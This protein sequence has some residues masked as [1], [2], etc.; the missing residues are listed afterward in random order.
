MRRFFLA[1]AAALVLTLAGG[2]VAAP[3][4]TVSAPQV[5]KRFKT[6]TTYLLRTNPQ[7]SYENVKAIGYGLNTPMTLQ[8]KYGRFV[9]YVL[10]GPDVEGAVNE[11]LVDLHTGEVGAPDA[12]GIYW[13]QDSTLSGEVYWTA[14]KRYGDNVVLWWYT[15]GETQATDAHFSRLSKIGRAHV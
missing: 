2:A 10:G 11:L 15:V 5:I 8:G 9:I 12:R 13:E 7:L 6:A 14:K 4:A 1:A 3:Q